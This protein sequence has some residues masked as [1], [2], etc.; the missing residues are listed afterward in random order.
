MHLTLNNLKSFLGVLVFG[1][2]LFLSLL[3]VPSGTFAQNDC[4]LLQATLSP[5]GLQSDG[6][7]SKNNTVTM[8]VV[9]ENCVGEI[10]EISIE[11]QDAGFA[12]ADIAIDIVDDRPFIVPSSELIK[13][14][15]IA[16]E[17]GCVESRGSERHQ[18]IYYIKI[19]DGLSFDAIDE[20][21]NGPAV[22][23]YNCENRE[24]DTSNKWDAK[25][26]TVTGAFST[27][28]SSIN[29]TDDPETSINAF[30]TTRNCK[31]DRITVEIHE[32]DGITI[33]TGADLP[34]SVT[35]VFD[36]IINGNEIPSTNIITVPLKAGDQFCSKEKDPDCNYIIKTLTLSGSSYNSDG[37]FLGNL[38]YNCDDKCDT[39]WT[40][41]EITSQDLTSEGSLPQFE[42]DEYELLA[43]L[44][45]ISRIGVGFTFGDYLN[46][47]F[48]LLIGVAGVLAVVVIV[49]RGI[50]YMMEESII[51]KGEAKKKI[52]GAIGGL[53]LAL[54]S[55]MLLNTINPQLVNLSLTV[56]TASI[57]IDVDIPQD[58]INGR[59]CINTVTGP[60]DKNEF[61]TT[62]ET[63]NTFRAK[64]RTDYNVSVT[65]TN[66]RTCL[67]VGDP[68]CTSVTSK[69]GNLNTSSIATIRNACSDCTIQITG[70][71]ECWLH[72]RRGTQNTF[73][74]PGSST[75]DLSFSKS[76]N[77]HIT[78]KERSGQ[79]RRL[80]KEQGTARFE[81]NGL[82]FLFESDHWHVGP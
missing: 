82:S 76:L 6:F 40:L 71:V 51:E 47:L 24:C 48:Q 68:G 10:L 22:L 59:T 73:H 31:D 43:P 5:N 54:G 50:Q 67:K 7:G 16:G 78:G 56:R 63:E 32:K 14:E 21:P 26:C 80:V 65:S 41:K 4:T 42:L 2:I 70:A 49:I 61:W 60:Y 33:A 75:I 34:V 20:A 58:F 23:K 77:K 36:K 57:N 64:L 28:S 13:L 11:A 35:R 52:W 69:K 25:I 66:G 79:I 30:I 39:L 17:E 72:G 55:F 27:P 81:K 38:K 45:G 19:S 37:T 3:L 15:L 8:N 1:S 29:Y 46:I 53:V 62:Q 18:C 74:Y 44:P 9:T 12:N